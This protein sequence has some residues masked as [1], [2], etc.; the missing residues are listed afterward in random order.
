MITYLLDSL[1]R[2]A[3][4]QLVSVHHEQAAS[5][6]A[7]ATGRITGKPGGLYAINGGTHP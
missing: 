7:D 3:T 4:I 1:N 2:Q 5:F 6:A